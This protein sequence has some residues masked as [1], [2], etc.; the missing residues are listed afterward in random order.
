MRK[1]NETQIDPQRTEITSDQHEPVASHSDETDDL[2]VSR[3][4]A[5]SVVAKY[6]AATAPVMVTLFAGKAEAGSFFR[7][8]PKNGSGLR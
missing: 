1:F 5:L 3:R 7:K 4:Q 8:R 6:S 2:G